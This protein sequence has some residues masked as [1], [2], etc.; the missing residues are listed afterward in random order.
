MSRYA[1]VS[2]DIA[3]RNPCRL[4][5]CAIASRDVTKSIT[6]KKGGS[7]VTCFERHFFAHRQKGK[8]DAMQH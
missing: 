6:E 5:S 8:I 1:A 2:R 4:L 3:Q 7:D